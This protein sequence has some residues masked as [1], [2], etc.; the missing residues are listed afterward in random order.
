MPEFAIHD[1]AATLATLTVI[2]A[3]LWKL[4]LWVRKDSR[5]DKAE[6]RIDG[7]YGQLVEQLRAEVA[8]LSKIVREMSD[9]LA[10]ERKARRAAEDAAEDLRARV[11]HLED[12][13]KGGGAW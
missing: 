9:E 4:V 8:R 12:A 11:A 10:A 3:A 7:G 5:T 6:G 13:M 1:P 2:A